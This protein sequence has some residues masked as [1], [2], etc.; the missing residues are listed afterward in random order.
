[1]FP[2]TQPDFIIF[3][4]WIGLKK[5]QFF[6]YVIC[7][8]QS[9]YWGWV[10]PCMILSH[11][12][13]FSLNWTSGLILWLF[14]I[15]DF[16]SWNFV[17]Y[18]VYIDSINIFQNFTCVWTLPFFDSRTFATCFSIELYNLSDHSHIFRIDNTRDEV[19][20]VVGVKILQFSFW[21]RF[22]GCH[23]GPS[24]NHILQLPPYKVEIRIS[25]LASRIYLGRNLWIYTITLFW[26]L[27]ILNIEIYAYKVDSITLN[28]QHCKDT[29]NFQCHVIFNFRSFFF[30]SSFSFLSSFC[31]SSSFPFSSFFL[32]IF[33]TVFF[34]KWQQYTPIWGKSCEIIKKK[35]LSGHWRSILFI[36]FMTSSW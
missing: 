15:W 7:I 18:L 22:A 27:N 19:M 5:E 16:F 11:L 31:L 2:H 28:I 24:F 36:F 25:A 3:A 30:P 10:S 8:S 13:L 34:R 17:L 1:M 33:L 20:K 14:F 12:N 6:C 26:V 4:N 29:I 9:N 23:W 32:V 35:M 21:C